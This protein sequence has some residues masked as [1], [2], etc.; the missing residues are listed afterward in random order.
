MGKAELTNWRDGRGTQKMK[1][2]GVVASGKEGKE[3]IW[4]SKEGLEKNGKPL[5][6]TSLV[7]I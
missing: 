2:F 1:K 7:L 4:E 6:V 5:G 3:A